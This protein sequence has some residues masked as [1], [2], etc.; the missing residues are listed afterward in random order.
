MTVLALRRGSDAQEAAEAE[1]V[2]QGLSHDLLVRGRVNFGEGAR[3]ALIPLAIAGVLAGLAGSNLAGI[4]AGRVLSWVVQPLLMLLG[5]IVTGGQVF[6]TRQVRSA[7]AESGDAELA[8]VD[9]AKVMAAAVS[10]FPR[11]FRPLLV[12]RFLL[13][14][15]GSAAVV[16]L[17]AVPASSSHY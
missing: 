2:A 6:A 16:V 9:V 3:E 10:V 17:L 8:R 11:W 13:V 1:V 5:G 12:G 15:A 7:F 4:G 14:T